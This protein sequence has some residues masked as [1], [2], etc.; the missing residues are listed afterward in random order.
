M[1]KVIKRYYLKNILNQIFK[2]KME[3]LLIFL[4]VFSISFFL[5]LLY[6]FGYNDNIEANIA[7]Q[8]NLQFEIENFELEDNSMVDDLA[9]LFDEIGKDERIAYYNYNLN[10][11]NIFGIS[12]NHFLSE[13]HYEIIEGRDF[14]NEELDEGLPLVIVSDREKL[15]EDGI[16]R[17]IQVGDRLFLDGLGSVPFEVIGIYRSDFRHQLTYGKNDRFVNSFGV[18]IPNQFILLNLQ[19]MQ[20][21]FTFNHVVYQVEDYRDYFAFMEDLRDQCNEFERSYSQ[22]SE[23]DISLTILESN[24]SNIL[25]SIKNI[26][27]VFNFIFLALFVILAAIFVFLIYYFFARKAKEI[28]LYVSLGQSYVKI[29]FHYLF[30]YLLIGML[31]TVAALVIGY[32]SSVLMEDV[33]LKQNLQLQFELLRFTMINLSAEKITSFAYSY[34]VLSCIKI[35]IEVMLMITGASIISVLS[36]LKLKNMRR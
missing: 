11:F 15:I 31:A 21:K 9:G 30:A 29:I 4:N 19:S 26:K 14:T 35:L 22:K 18:L 6:F 3:S 28:Q 8:L 13:N 25:L 23:K 20:A 7:N 36:V 2:K 16:E 17:K 1:K 10:N 32:F 27:T 34:T 5:S 24:E 33:L 12:K